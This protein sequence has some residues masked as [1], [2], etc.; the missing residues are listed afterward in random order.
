MD[1]IQPIQLTIPQAAEALQCSPRQIHYM[2]QSG[3]LRRVKVGR[4][5]RIPVSELHRWQ[6]E[7]LRDGQ[8]TK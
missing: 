2:I 4:K 6:Q 5:V 1:V 8:T 3:E 7:Q